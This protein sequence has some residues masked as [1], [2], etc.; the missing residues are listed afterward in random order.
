M[1]T[2]RPARRSLA[3]RLI[4]LLA[5]AVTLIGCVIVAA[6]TAIRPVEPAASESRAKVI[7]R[8]KAVIQAECEKASG[9]DWERWQRETAPH[10]VAL[11]ARIDHPKP[12]DPSREPW[13]DGRPRVL[14][15][16]DDFPLVE[17]Q[18]D[19]GLDYLYDGDRLDQFRRDR[20]VVAAS[21]W[22]RQ[23]GIDLIF[24]PVPK[25]T[26]VYAEHFVDNC[27]QDGIVGSQVR[28]S[29]FELLDNDVEVVDGLPLYR[30]ERDPDPEYIY[31]AADTHW[32]PRA[33]RIM[34][35]EVAARVQRY[36]FGAEA[37]AVP[38]IVKTTPAPFD[39]QL[40][41][42][43]VKEGDLP[44]MDGWAYLTAKQRERVEVVQARTIEHV[45]LPD[46]SEPRDDPNSPVLLIGNS[47][48]VNFRELLIK[49]LNLFIRT[50]S[51]PGETTEEFIAFLREPELLDGCRVLVWV[52]SAEHLAHLHPMPAPIMKVLEP[53]K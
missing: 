1:N 14:E 12:F 31:N 9:G 37:R 45:T 51:A 43:S 24:L 49:E 3:V 16:K 36:Q 11:K 42:S 13:L 6:R 30:P 17:V 46:G 19:K 27:P 15:A 34:A 52:L 20:A 8:D 35:R 33:M 50:R 44:R 23:R 22:L 26:E 40:V 18:P 41:P 2:D 32:G 4:L 5:L 47:F 38:P 53:A 28:R 29:V 25:M 10:R 48:I 21:R 39:I 7:A